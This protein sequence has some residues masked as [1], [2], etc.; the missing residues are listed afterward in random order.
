MTHAHDAANRMISAGGG[1]LGQYGYDGD[2]MRVKKV[3]VGGTV[4]YVRSSKLGN[5]AFEVTSAGVQR[6]YVY[7][8]DKLLAQQSIDG[9]FYWVHTDHLGTARKLTNSS[10]TVVYRG[11]FDPHGKVL[12]EWGGAN[13]IE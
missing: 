7:A 10:G 3:E 4:W 2:G 13:L 8:G 1:A 6:A 11:E 12:L 5:A 9:Q